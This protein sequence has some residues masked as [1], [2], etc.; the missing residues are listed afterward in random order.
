M[1]QARRNACGAPARAV[2]LYVADQ[3][4][5]SLDTRPPGTFRQRG[6][7]SLQRLFRAHFPELVARI[8]CTNP[9]CKAE[10]FRPFSCKVFHLCPSCSQKGTSLFGEYLN[11]RLLLRLP[12]RQVVFTFPKVLRIFFRHGRKLYGE[13]SKLV[14][15][16][17]QGFYNAAA[18]RKIQSAAVIVYASEGDFVRWNPHLHGVFL[19][20][21][22]GREGRFLQ[23]PTLDL[24]KLSQCFRSGMIAFFLQRAL[25]NERLAKNML[26]WTHSGFSVDSSVKIPAPSS[27]TREALAQ[28]IER[29][30]WLYGTAMVWHPCSIGAARDCF[31]RTG[32]AHVG[33]EKR[34]S[35]GPG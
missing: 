16:L 33:R 13:V 34:R 31:R 12:H 10:Y 11:E 19:E 22:F 17:I 1:D 6:T 18:G 3:L 32:L 27:K 2:S 29:A 15:R 5:L 14:Y 30:C 24:A 21:G 20:G 23:V 25:M 26:D 35:S 4:E 28:Y 7:S 9:R 8:K